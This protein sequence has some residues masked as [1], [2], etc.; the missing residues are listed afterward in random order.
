MKKLFLSLALL[1]GLTGFAQAG[2]YGGGAAAITTGTAISPSSATIQNRLLV[3]TGSSVSTMTSTAFTMA[4]GSNITV[5]L[6]TVRNQLL[7]G[8]GSSVSTMT[9]T[10]LTMAA[11]STLAVDSTTIRNQLLVGTGSSVSTQTATS[12]TMT[13]GT[14][15]IRTSGFTSTVTGSSVSVAGANISTVAAVS[16]IKF[17][18]GTT[19]VSSPTA[20]ALTFSWVLNPTGVKLSTNS[21]AVNSSSNVVIPALLCDDTANEFV[22]WSTYMDVYNGGSLSADVTFSMVTGT[23]GTVSFDGNIMCISPLDA[24]DTDTESYATTTSSA[25]TV[26]GTAGYLT[27]AV[28]SLTNDSCA[29]GDVVV[30]RL[31]VNSNGTAAS[32]AE[33]RPSRIYEP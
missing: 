28:W 5:D 13:G 31:Q 17:T 11:D 7:A 12:L 25:V 32:D 14:M 1:C 26:P 27:N 23:T 29:K 2:S 30:F 4:S 19:L 20:T 9:S 18:D 24:A 16:Q 21:C 15:T 8:T 22:T 6:T 33:I 10:A 3:G